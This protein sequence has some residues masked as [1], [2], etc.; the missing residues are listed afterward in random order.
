MEGSNSGVSASDGGVTFLRH[1]QHSCVCVCVGG[2]VRGNIIFWARHHVRR[3]FHDRSSSLSNKSG[4]V[5]PAERFQNATGR[6]VREIF[7]S[8]VSSL[9]TMSLAKKQ[10]DA[11]EGAKSNIR[12]KQSSY[13]IVSLLNNA[14]T[15]GDAAKRD[16]G[17][18][19]KFY[20][21]CNQLVKYNGAVL[22]PANFVGSIGP[23]A[24]GQTGVNDCN[25]GHAK[26]LLN[27]SREWPQQLFF[28]DVNYCCGKKQAWE[29]KNNPAEQQKNRSRLPAVGKGRRDATDR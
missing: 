11:E 1:R 22:I 25:R 15:Q 7:A 2:S 18:V 14:R 27:I 29:H 6:D 13:Q 4:F 3:S 23:P 17:R 20:I 12:N 24:Q 5:L 16:L 10:P 9:A 19:G 8:L 26:N 21:T 28:R